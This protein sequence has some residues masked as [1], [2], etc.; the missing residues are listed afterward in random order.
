MF[1]N[2]F[3]KKN[4][5]CQPNSGKD[6]TCT[7]RSTLQQIKQAVFREKKEEYYKYILIIIY[8]YIK[9]TYKLNINKEK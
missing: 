7:C 1:D 4:K 8:M 6:S 9:Y 2:L 5:N 3:R